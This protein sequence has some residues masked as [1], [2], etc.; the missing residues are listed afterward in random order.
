MAN[1]NWPER[2]KGRRV[3]EVSP[4]ISRRVTKEANHKSKTTISAE[5]VMCSRGKCESELEITLDEQR[6]P[7]NSV[8][9]RIGTLYYQNS[10]LASSSTSESGRPTLELTRTQKKRIQRQYCTFLK[11]KDDT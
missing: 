11:N 8:F 7:T 4:Q 5:V 10:V 2:Q 9:D 3:A 6:Q 1:L